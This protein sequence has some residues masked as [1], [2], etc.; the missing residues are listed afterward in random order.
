MEFENTQ[1]N[2]LAKLP[3]LKLGSM[4]CGRSGLNNIFRSRIMIYSRSSR[5]GIHGY[6]LLKKPPPQES[7]SLTGHGMP[8]VINLTFRLALKACA[9]LSTNNINT[10]N[11]EV[12][13]ATTKVNT[14]STEISIHDDDLEEMDLKWDLWLTYMHYYNVSTAI[15]WD[16]LPRNA[17]H[18]GVKTTEIGYQGC[19][20]IKALLR[21]RCFE[22]QCVAIDVLAF[23]WS[24]IGNDEDEV[25]S[26]IVVKKKT[27]IPTAA[28]IKKLVRKQ[29]RY[30]EMYSGC[31]RHMTGN[32]AH[33]LDFKVFDGGL[34]LLVEEPMDGRILAKRSALKRFEDMTN[35]MCCLSYRPEQTT[36]PRVDEAL[37]P[38]TKHCLC[39]IW[40]SL[41][42]TFNRVLIVKPHN[43]TPYELF[44]GFKPAIGFMKPFGC[45]VTILNTLDKLGKFLMAK[46]D[47]GFFVRY[48]V[49]QVFPE[50]STSSQQDQ[51]NQDCIIMPIWK[52]ASYFG[53]VAPRSVVDA[54][55]QEK[56]VN[57]ARPEIN[58][59]SREVSTAIPEVNIANPEDLVG[60]S[61][62]SED[63]QVE[64]QEVEIGNI[65]Q[66][67][68]VPTTPHTR[69]HKDHPIQHVIGD[70]QEDSS[71]SSYMSFCL[72]P[73]SGRT[74][75]SFIKALSASAMGRSYAGGTSA[76]R[77]QMVGFLYMVGSLMY[78]YASRTAIHVFAVRAC[79]KDSPLELVAYTD[80]DYAG[81]TQDRKST[82]G[83]CQFL[84]K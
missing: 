39:C 16:I 59:G 47:E 15:K 22:K 41:S 32:I 75:K 14:A 72:F 43:K 17:E 23:D 7:G 38:F 62:A 27:V 48:S 54:Q 13:T 4:K 21:L 49:I 55:I 80:S 34:L 60:P 18:L 42:L 8:D 44:R 45:H 68:A 82:T 76:V 63:T 12:S 56:V 69:I 84:G 83:G 26:P 37:I 71:G 79:C 77:M 5:M 30:A 66:T 29:V 6:L 11:P 50:S 33:L 28:K 58:T 1:N 25:E 36:E 67:Y 65:P 81:A 64:D 61:H 46:S 35:Y 3:M 51:D 24:D 73:L 20:K 9:K 70:V 78:L 74:K 40:I 53:D 57:T 10:V 52:D 31:S 2:A 19:I